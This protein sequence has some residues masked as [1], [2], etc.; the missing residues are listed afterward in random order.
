MSL[1]T[2]LDWLLLKPKLKRMAG[3]ALAP[4]PTREP[5]PFFK[6]WS[7]VSVLRQSSVLMNLAADSVLE[8]KAEDEGE[9]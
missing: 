3:P 9:D 4:V 7:R 6:F 5:N 2:W 1:A 8:V